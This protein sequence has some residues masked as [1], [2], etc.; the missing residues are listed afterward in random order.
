M[1][2]HVPLSTDSFSPIGAFLKR[3]K[4]SSRQTHPARL[5]SLSPSADGSNQWLFDILC[6]ERSGPPSRIDPWLW[7]RNLG[8]GKTDR[9][10]VAGIQG[11]CLRSDRSWFLGPA[12]DSLY[13]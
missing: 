11:I 9:C 13:P 10:P 3:T 4:H 5:E 12:K 2:F 1:K 8:M 7:G 6:R